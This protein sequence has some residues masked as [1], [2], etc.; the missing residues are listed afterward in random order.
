MRRPHQRQS[1]RPRRPL[2]RGRV[3]RYAPGRN[4]TYGL[5]L[6]R[7]TLYPL[8]YR[9]VGTI[10]PAAAE[11]VGY[12]GADGAPR[13]DR[14]ARVPRAV[15]HLPQRRHALPGRPGRDLARR[16]GRLRRGRSR[17]ALR[18]GDRHARMPGSSSTCEPLLGDDPL[19]IGAILDRLGAAPGRDGGQV[20][21]RRRPARPA[22]Q[23]LRPAAVAHPRAR[24]ARRRRR[25]T[26]S[27]STRVEGTADRA[28]AA[29]RRYHA[30]KIKVGGPADLERVRT[31]RA[32][33]AGRADPGRRQRGLDG[34]LDA[35]ARPRAR[36][37][38]ASS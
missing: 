2:R 7:R 27:R 19:A 5:A 34:A 9:R 24:P 38:S 29:R 35:R 4:R 1:G 30:L 20:R 26:R 33:G 8:S 25:A 6:R 14:H 15:R 37:R 3:G 13:E 23:D 22:R 21:G 16:P 12:A 10:L 32:A 18:R 36:A 31:V 17:R 28:A 11:P